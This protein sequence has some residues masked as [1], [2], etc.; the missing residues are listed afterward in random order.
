MNDIVESKTQSRP[1]N[2]T[3]EITV[4]LEPTLPEQ[5]TEEVKEEAKPEVTTKLNSEEFRLEM[6]RGV[7][8]SLA[9]TAGIFSEVIEVDIEQILK[10]PKPFLETFE[11]AKKEG[12]ATQ[13][14][15]DQI[16]P[17]IRIL[18]NA[19]ELQDLK[20]AAAKNDKPIQSNTEEEEMTTAT[21]AAPAAT[22]TPAAAPAQVNQDLPTTNNLVA[23][24]KMNPWVGVGLASAA[25]LAVTGFDMVMNGDLSKERILGSVAATVV[26]G[27]AQ[28]VVQQ[29]LTN[30]QSTAVNSAVGLVMGAGVGTIA[31]Y[32]IG[33]VSETAEEVDSL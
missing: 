9:E 30:E 27:G 11:N 5:P 20:A 8:K 22:V 19:A 13:D 23:S 28:Y 24:E 7:W 29:Y 2:E 21:N 33:L 26:A 16:E 32:G 15:L 18:V 6:E 31:R 4:V 17:F 12:K 1:I 10:N 14:D 25:A 3:T